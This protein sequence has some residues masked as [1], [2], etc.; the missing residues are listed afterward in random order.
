[1]L[2][3]TERLAAVRNALRTYPVVAL[4]G[5]RQSGKT[6]LAREIAKGRDATWFDMEN[7]V[8]VGR[9]TAP[10]DVLRELRGL[11]VIDEVQRRP[12]L[13]PILRVLADR[14]RKPA[15][16]LLLG[17][18][19]PDLVKGVTETLA[20]RVA[21]IDLG[22]FDLREVEPSR[23]DALWTRGGLPPSFVAR[24]EDASFVWR[25]NYILN[26]LRRDVPEL[27]IAIPS[28]AMER[29]WTMLAHFHGGIWNAAEFA[30]SMGTSEPTARKYLDILTGAYV[31]RQL[32][33][34]HENIGKRQVKAPKVYVRDTGLLH[35][36]LLIHDK[37]ELLGHV[38]RGASWEGFVVEQ[39]LSLLG[40][41]AGFFWGTYQGAELDLL[42]FH[43][44]KRFGFEVKMADAPAFTKSM[45]IAIE[46]LKLSR[47]FVVHHGM[48]SWKLSEKTE[49]L[50]IR[51]L[52]ARLRNLR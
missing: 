32:Q 6:T 22:G 33:P 19:S 7:P 42:V 52:P 31:A 12:E 1:M 20:G 5:P 28:S 2:R 15:R 10:M 21:H 34:W 9:L 23:C 25:R 16:F 18:A 37:S 47:L 48:Q 38:K 43:R 26:F 30:R 3:R 17:S 11:V 13:Y 8:D 35:A 36:L 41:V 45:G 51:D 39:I 44:G 46:D 49:V 40:D 27:G 29:F 50:S 4:H 14:P 24:T